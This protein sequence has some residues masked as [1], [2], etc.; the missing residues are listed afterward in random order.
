MDERDPLRV[1]IVSIVEELPP[2][3]SGQSRDYAKVVF[4]LG[5]HG[6]EFPVYV[7]RT[8]VADENLIQVARHYFHLQIRGIADATA[9]WKLSEADCQKIASPAPQKTPQSRVAVVPA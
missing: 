9:S 5:T 8:H 2:G 6:P 3:S 1:R 7:H 4:K